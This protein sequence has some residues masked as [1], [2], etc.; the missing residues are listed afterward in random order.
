VLFYHALF[1]T[2]E[3]KLHR[4]GSGIGVCLV[5]VRIESSRCTL[6]KDNIYKYKLFYKAFKIN[7]VFKTVFLSWLAGVSLAQVCWHSL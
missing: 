3:I 5:L 6:L 7:K 1:F 4:R 2:L